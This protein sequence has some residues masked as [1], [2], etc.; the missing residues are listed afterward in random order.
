M[1]TL[2]GYSI[3][4]YLALTLALT[5]YASHYDDIPDFYLP[6]PAA[7]EFPPA[8]NFAKMENAQ[9]KKQA[10]FDYFTPIV[11]Q[12]NANVSAER[13]VLLAIEDQYYADGT[14][15]EH[16]I[17]VIDTLSEEYG[18]E[19]RED[20]IEQI[21]ALLKRVNIVPTSLALAQAANESGWGTSRFARKGNNYFGMW[22]Y[23]KGCGYVPNARASGAKHEVRK[24]S[25]P[26]ES[27]KAY[28]HNINTHR[29]Y[30][31]LRSIRQQAVNSGTP[32][33]GEL[34]ADGLLNYSERREDYVAE[35]KGM[36]RSNELDS[37]RLI[38]TTD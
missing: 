7:V 22:C 11:H 19:L 32:I 1:K 5:F 14:I 26:A 35:I 9:E 6:Q 33:S 3:I 38:L 23:S 17:E 18:I 24:F 16:G 15:S 8:P 31:L 30:R 34:L 27:V 12:I 20:K 21:T 28:V 29:A 13:D 2:L 4:V 25:S 10:F 37:E 36:I